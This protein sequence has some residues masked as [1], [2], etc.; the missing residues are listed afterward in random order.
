VLVEII[1]YC[2]SEPL[3]LDQEQ[4]GAERSH[5]SVLQH[6]QETL[7]WDELLSWQMQM[8]MKSMVA[9]LVL[10]LLMLLLKAPVPL[11]ASSHTHT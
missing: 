8:Q 1:S 6:L 4:S 3:C 9:P 7:L 5:A 11:P 2:K 10:M